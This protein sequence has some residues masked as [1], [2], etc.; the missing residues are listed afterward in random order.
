MRASKILQIEFDF[1]HDWW[2][3]MKLFEICFP[4][5]V[6]FLPIG[7]NCAPLIAD[8]FLFCYEREFMSNIYNSKRYDFID[9]FNYTSRYLDGTF[10]IANTEFEKHIPY[11]YPTELQLN[12]AILQFKKLLS[13]I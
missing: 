5:Y 4:D 3:E 10:T 6:Q 1:R 11:I 12:K 7:T 2:N 8:L 9:M 13:L